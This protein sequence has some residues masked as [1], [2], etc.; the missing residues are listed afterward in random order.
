MTEETNTLPAVIGNER[1]TMLT[2][3]QLVARYHDSITLRTL[4]NWRT[5]KQGPEWVKIGRN[6]FYTLE[7]VRNWEKRRTINP[8]R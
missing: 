8:N 4:R 7:A 6:V 2:P 5:I 3:E 1:D